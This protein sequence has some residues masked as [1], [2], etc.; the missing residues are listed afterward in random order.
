MPVIPGDGKAEGKEATAGTDRRTFIR[1]AGAAAVLGAAGLS[2]ALAESAGASPQPPQGS[3]VEDPK[4]PPGLKR[5]AMLSSKYAVSY[6]KSL[7]AAMGIMTSYFGALS[8]RDLK[9]IA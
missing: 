5:P 4:V 2:P 1:N 8:R 9:G 7:P 3:D 6:E